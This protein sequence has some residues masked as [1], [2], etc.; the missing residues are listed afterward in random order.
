ME[1]FNVIAG[2]CSIISL[3]I[4]IFVASKVIKISNNFNNNSSRKQVVLGK[5]NKTAGNDMKNV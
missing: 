3:F 4:S 2:V 5:K 1:L